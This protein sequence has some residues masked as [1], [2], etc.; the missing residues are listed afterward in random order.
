VEQGIAELEAQAAEWEIK[1][2][3]ETDPRA[4]A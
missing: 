4:Y 1:A 2:N 3:K